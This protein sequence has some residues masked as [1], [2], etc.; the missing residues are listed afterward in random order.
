MCRQE[1]TYADDDRIRT[2]NNM[3]LSPLYG[4]GGDKIITVILIPFLHITGNVWL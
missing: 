2:K 1:A 3:Y 4:E